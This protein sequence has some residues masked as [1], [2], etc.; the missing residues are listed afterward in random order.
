MQTR[1]SNFGNG[2]PEEHFCE[3]ILK[4]GNWPRKRC[5]LKGF[6]FLALESILFSGED[7][8]RYFGRGSPNENFCEIVLK[9]S[10]WP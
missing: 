3:I 5:R 6:L 2:S 10:H 7:N 8:S 4:L 9:L 1:F